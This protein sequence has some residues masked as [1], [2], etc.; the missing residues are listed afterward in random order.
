V[1]KKS[2]LNRVGKTARLEGKTILG[3]VK[4]GRGRISLD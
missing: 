1:R 3:A 2:R 4:A